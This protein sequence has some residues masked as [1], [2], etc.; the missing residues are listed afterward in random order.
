MA[1]FERSNMADS[2]YCPPFQKW[3][4]QKIIGIIKKNG[5]SFEHE[6]GGIFSFYIDKNVFENMYTLYLQ[7]TQ[8]YICEPNI[9][10]SDGI[11]SY[12][13]LDDFLACE[14]NRRRNNL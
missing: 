4:K 11:K 12:K 5:F 9:R 14:M 8:L 13:K 10:I 2:N 1:I 7:R 3:N 6:Y